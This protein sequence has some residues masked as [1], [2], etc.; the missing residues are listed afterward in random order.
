MTA[1]VSVRRLAPLFRA[2]QLGEELARD[3]SLAQAALAPVPRLA[4]ALQE[5]SRQEAFHANLFGAALQCIPGRH[6]CP[7]RF[8]RALASY[9][10][11][12]QA[13]IFEGNLLASM[14]GLQCGFEGLGAVA[15]RFPPGPIAA[16]C[17]R[18]VP[19]RAVILR[20]EEA[21][22]RLGQWWARRVGAVDASRVGTALRVYSA[23]A[24]EIT[25]AGLHELEILNIDAQHYR[26]ASSEHIAHLRTACSN[27]GDS[28][29][30]YRAW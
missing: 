11:K 23:L 8:A 4:R 28:E 18:L 19:L 3:I 16:I 14:L 6:L 25:A 26:C 22:H 29:H 7:P 5:Q 30:S 21:H 15:L 13:D 12:L 24:E 2:V 27:V 17:D 9:R 10:A 1:I 20:Q